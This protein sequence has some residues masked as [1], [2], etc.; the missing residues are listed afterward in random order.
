MKYFISSLGFWSKN[1]TSILN[2]NILLLKNTKKTNMNNHLLPQSI[3]YKKD[4]HFAVVNP[5][6]S[7]GQA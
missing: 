3:E 1:V 7:L 4:W 2:K 5:G 6:P